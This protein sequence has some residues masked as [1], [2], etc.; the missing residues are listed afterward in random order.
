MRFPPK[1]GEDFYVITPPSK[2]DA[3]TVGRLSLRLSNSA[4]NHAR[5]MI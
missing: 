4:L 1:E 2:M 3:K 5:I